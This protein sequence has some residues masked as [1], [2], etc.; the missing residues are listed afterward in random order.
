MPASDPYPAERVVPYDP[1]WP[2]LY[3]AVAVRVRAALGPRWAIEHVGSTSV[4]GLSAKPV[5]DVALRMPEGCDPDSVR[6]AFASLGWTSPIPIDEHLAMFELDNGI[7]R[8]NGHLLTA[9]QWPGSPLRLFARW[10]REHPADRIRYQELK[11][12]LV[13]SGVWGPE[14]TAAKTEFVLA[15]VA[16][17]RRAC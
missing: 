13:A 1:R 3:E 4:P 12:A 17:A 10:L 15:V 2:A 11:T 8:V 14:Y 7:R 5:I 6:A 16:R 9:A